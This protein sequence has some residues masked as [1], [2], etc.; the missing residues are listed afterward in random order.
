MQDIIERSKL[1]P[2]QLAKCLKSVKSIAESRQE[3]EAFVRTSIPENKRDRV[4][5]IIQGLEH[6]DDFAI[7][8]RLMG[9][10][11][12]LVR[13]DQT[14]LID[15][16]SQNAPDFLATF[17]PGC[18]VMGKSKDAIDLRYNCFVEVKSCKDQSLK[19]SKKDLAVR[20]RFAQQYGLP[21]IF[22]R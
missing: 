3:F 2:V 14:P 21:L 20:A 12:A 1:S 4:V 11:E 6:E 22:G 8:C 9:T 7:L 10:C 16:G 19:I 5:Q 15:N 13:L 18:H 17:R